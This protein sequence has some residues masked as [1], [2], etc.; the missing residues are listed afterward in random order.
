[1]N[2]RPS[3]SDCEAVSGA[4][5]SLTGSKSRAR[6]SATR[7]AAVTVLAAGSGSAPAAPGLVRWRVD[8]SPRSG[9]FAAPS[10]RAAVPPSA[11]VVPGLAKPPL[12]S[13]AAARDRCL[14]YA[15]GPGPRGAP[16]AARRLRQAPA[17][18]PKG[19]HGWRLTL[20]LMDGYATLYCGG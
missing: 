9:P 2:C 1:L 17:L 12:H 5:R 11:A 20:C 4:P 3:L 16:A 14:R 8:T 7:H 18:P 15:L 13:L 10:M 19:L 6:R